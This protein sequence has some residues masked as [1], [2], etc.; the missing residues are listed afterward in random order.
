LKIDNDEFDEK[1]EIE[2]TH[3]HFCKIKLTDEN[4]SMHRVFFKDNGKPNVGCVCLKCKEIF[5]KFNSPSNNKTEKEVE[6]ELIKQGW[7]Y[8]TLK[9]KEEMEFNTIN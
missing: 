1:I 3:C 9:A 6:L 2:K 8:E 7:T 4:I 5:Y